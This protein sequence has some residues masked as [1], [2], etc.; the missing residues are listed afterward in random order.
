M[1]MH[2]Q[3][4]SQNI[5]DNLP[6]L[7]QPAAALADEITHYLSL[8]VELPVNGDV[9]AWWKS[10]EKTYP[11]LSRMARDYLMIPGACIFLLCCRN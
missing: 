2:S 6:A 1:L 3:R 4:V 8:D 5:F 9:F 11:R 7:A 10:K